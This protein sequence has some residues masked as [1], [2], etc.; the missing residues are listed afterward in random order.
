MTGI[1]LEEVGNF[2][3]TVTNM[4]QNKNWQVSKLMD[5]AEKDTEY[6]IDYKSKV[7]KRCFICGAICNKDLSFEYYCRWGN[8]CQT[9]CYISKID[10]KKTP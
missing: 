2:V 3:K 7:K 5:D 9:R 1:F 6:N 10:K 8:K 4:D